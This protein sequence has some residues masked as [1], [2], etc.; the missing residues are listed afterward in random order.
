MGWVGG[1]VADKRL[2]G[3]AAQSLAR[4]FGP[5]GVH[6]SH[7]IID[8][9]RGR[10]V[11]WSPRWLT[12]HGIWLLA[13]LIDTDRVKGFAGGPTE[14]DSRLSPDAIAEAYVFLANQPKSAWTQ[15][16]PAYCP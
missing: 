4:E 11:W 7:T 15:G 1:V 13:G 14:A 16:T 10:K 8:G 5:Q 2:V 9:K 12:L 3:C 6:V